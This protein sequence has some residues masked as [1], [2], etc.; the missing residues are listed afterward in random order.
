MKLK[1]FEKHLTKY[2]CKLLREGGN[3][4]IWVNNANLKQSAVIMN[5]NFSK[6]YILNNKLWKSYFPF[7]IS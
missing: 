1:D 6:V 7:K 2:G 4:S 5:L 3:H